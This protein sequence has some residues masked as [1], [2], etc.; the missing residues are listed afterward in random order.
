MKPPLHIQVRDM[1]FVPK[2]RHQDL[3]NPK[4]CYLVSA[5]SSRLIIVK[6]VRDR[7]CEIR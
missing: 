4:G 2:N 5:H 6:R 1:D 7:S 3:T